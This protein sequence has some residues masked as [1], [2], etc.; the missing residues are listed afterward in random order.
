[1]GNLGLDKRLRELEVDKMIICG[2]C[3]DICVLYTTADARNRNYEVEVPTDCVATFDPQA[4]EWALDHIEK[5]LGGK[6]TAAVS[7]G[8]AS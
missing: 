2:V 6:L 5:I 1:M 3:T 7:S 8:T 4:H